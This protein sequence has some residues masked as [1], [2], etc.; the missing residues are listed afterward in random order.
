MREE[1]RVHSLY[2]LFILECEIALAR[3]NPGRLDWRDILVHKLLLWND[4]GQ[5][6]RSWKLRGSAA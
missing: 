1:G 3:P 4:L 2:G 6:W 5:P